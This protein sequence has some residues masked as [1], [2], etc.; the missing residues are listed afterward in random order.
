MTERLYYTNAYCTCFSARVIER[1][2]WDGC[3][4]VVLDR[5]AFYPTSGGQ[6]AD[7]GVLGGVAVVDVQARGDNAVIHVLESPLP[8]DEKEIEGEIDWSRRFD[9]MQQHT[10]QHVLSAAFERILDA[11]TVG[12]HLGT[13]VSTIDLNVP[14][15]APEAVTP[16]EGLVN[17]VV[18]ENRPVN[19]RFVDSDELA[20]LPLRRPPAVDGPVRIVEVSDFDVNPC[21]GTHVARTGEIGLVRIARLDYRGD[22]TRVEFLCGSRALRDYRAKSAVIN[23]LATMLTVGY[24]E[25]DQAVERLQGEAKQL[26]TD[27]RRTREGLLK[28]EAAELFEAAVPRGAYR[29]VQQVLQGRDPGELRALAQE[30]TR[31]F[32]V[33]VLLAG[34]GERTHLC[35]ACSEGVDLDMAALLQ[36]AC[37]QLG[38]K[39]GGKPHLAQGS[40]PTTDLARV[41]AVMSDLDVQE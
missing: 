10:G 20:A 32:E 30:L 21:G 28:V 9:H 26:R 2:T 4:A 25:L 18:W 38:G 8:K 12:F 15:L 35:F 5:T 29:V 14:R 34:V 24:W 23:Q 22:E 6:P 16:V 33:S 37:A 31:R 3:P 41:R 13:D 40:A 36:E 1:V 39:G 11:D 19:V 17:Q 7:L 27:L